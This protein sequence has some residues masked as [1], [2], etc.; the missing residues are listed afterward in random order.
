VDRGLGK[1]DIAKL[2]YGNILRVMQQAERVATR[3]KHQT[4]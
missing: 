1:E 3:L 2:C 4:N